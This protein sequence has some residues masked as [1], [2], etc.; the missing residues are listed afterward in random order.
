[1]MGDLGGNRRGRRQRRATSRV[2]GTKIA[3]SRQSRENRDY[4]EGEPRSAGPFHNV[5]PRDLLLRSP[6]GLARK[7]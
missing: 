3:R 7:L 2:G 1:M 6:V 5:R 4:G